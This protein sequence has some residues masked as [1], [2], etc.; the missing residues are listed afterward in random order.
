VSTCTSGGASIR[1]FRLPYRFHG[2]AEHLVGHVFDALPAGTGGAVV[3][4]DAKKVIPVDEDVRRGSAHSH[5]APD[6]VTRA[7]PAGRYSFG[8]TRPPAPV[9]VRAAAR[10]DEHGPTRSPPLHPPSPFVHQSVVMAAEQQ[11]VVQARVPSVGPVPHVVAVGEAESAAGEAAAAVA[12]FECAAQ[13]RRD[14]P[15][16]AADIGEAAA[17]LS[18][19]AERAWWDSRVLDHYPQG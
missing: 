16:A 7:P 12:S 15:C 10:V 18:M 13:R 5:G 1:A 8:P 3:G 19:M 6:H 4:V 2:S 17:K 11:G 14:R 9:E